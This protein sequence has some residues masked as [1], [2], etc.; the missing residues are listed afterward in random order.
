MANYIHI[1]MMAQCHCR[2]AGLLGP[3]SR[4]AAHARVRLTAD[5]RPESPILLNNSMF[6]RLGFAADGQRKERRD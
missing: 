6:E 5:R 4:T 2:L 1:D 3:P